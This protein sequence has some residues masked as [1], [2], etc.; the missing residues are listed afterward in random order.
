MTDTPAE[1]DVAII[2]AGPAGLFAA[3]QCAM[4]RLN[5]VLIDVLP[6]VGGQC[7]ALYPEKPIY[8]IPACPAVEGAQLIARLEEQIAPFNIPRLLKHRVESLE[9]HRGNFTLGTNQG[10]TLKAKAI[11]I[12]AG[13]GAFGP[14]RPPLEGL[15]AFEDTGAVQYYVRRKADFAGRRIV[16]AG[17]GDSALDWALSLK[18]NAEKLYL[19]H[20]R[21]RFRG[22]PE[23]LRQL[24]EAVAAGQ[25]EKVVPYQLH[26]LHGQNG[27]LEGVEV[28]DLD[29]AT[30]M[31]EADVLLPFFGL[32]TDLGPVARW[33][34]DT[35]R[36]TIPVTPS[37][38]ETSLPGVFAVGDVATYPGK[39]KLILQGFSEAAMAAHAIYPIVNPDQALHFEYSTSKGV[40]A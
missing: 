17:G 37:S 1:T 14:N 36:S 19:V 30:R 32:A 2:G 29:G 38:C 26:A 39:L 21:D 16:I 18:D 12:A 40:P 27:A 6:E 15:E 24:D 23:S 34:M 4:L 25:I 33:G 28:A 35:M 22:A 10:T 9:G 31:L 11:I 13:A 7:A 3:F 20:R 5:C 8:D